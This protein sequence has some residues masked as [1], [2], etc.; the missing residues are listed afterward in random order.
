[1]RELTR[2]ADGSPC[3]THTQSRSPSRSSSGSSLHNIITLQDKKREKDSKFKEKNVERYQW[4]LDIRD[5][6]RRRPGDDGYDPSTLYVPPAAYSKMTAFEQQ[7][8]D[9]KSKHFDTV[10]FFKKGKFYELYEGDAGMHSAHSRGPRLGRATRPRLSL[11]EHSP[12]I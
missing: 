9:V 5:A 11:A 1:V 12:T 8:W 3:V 7:F 2:I 6:E 4:L 10:V